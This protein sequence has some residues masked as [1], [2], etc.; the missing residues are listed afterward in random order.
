ME[1]LAN[2]SE[3]G[4]GIE[5]EDVIGYKGDYFWIIDGATDLFNLDFFGCQDDVAHYV[6]QLSECIAGSVNNNLEMNKIIKKAIY[7]TNKI[8]NLEVDN[9][10]AYELPSFAILF[11]KLEMNKCK[12]FVLGDCILQIKN[13]SNIIQIRDNRIKTFSKKNRVGFEELKKNNKLNYF[14]EKKLY[15]DTRKYMNRID[16]YWIGSADAKGLEHGIEGEVD[17][18]QNTICLGY[19][20][21]L[22]EAFE[23]FDVAK[24]NK[25]IFDKKTLEKVVRQLRELQ[26]KDTQRECTR[27]R[28]KDD[29]SYILVR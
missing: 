1:I 23:L 14:S 3:C 5:N 24:I 27:V 21:G 2:Y 12:Y 16:G 9:Y 29:L 10:Y 20:D 19:S 28:V 17:T 6:K 4:D 25:D 8:L 7:M 11:V 13:K 26:Q 22:L 15:I 18:D